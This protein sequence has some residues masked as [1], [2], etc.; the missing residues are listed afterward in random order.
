M[1][2]FGTLILLTTVYSFPMIALYPIEE[3]QNSSINR[4]W[5]NFFNPIDHMF[6]SMNSFF[7]FQ[8]PVL[9]ERIVDTVTEITPMGYRKITETVELVDANGRVDAI[10]TRIT[11]EYDFNPNAEGG[12]L[13]TNSEEKEDFVEDIV[14]DIV[15]DIQS[16]IDDS[17]NEEENQDQG[18]KRQPDNNDEILLTDLLNNVFNNV[19]KFEDSNSLIEATDQDLQEISQNDDAVDLIEED[20]KNGDEEERDLFNLIGNFL[21]GSTIEFSDSEENDID[22]DDDDDRIEDLDD[23]D[24]EEEDWEDDEEDEDGDDEDESEDIEDQPYNKSEEEIA[25]INSIMESD[26]PA[27]MKEQVLGSDYVQITE[28][29]IDED[30]DDDIMDEDEEEMP[31]SDDPNDLLD[32][33]DE[34]DDVED[35]DDPE[36]NGNTPNVNGLENFLNK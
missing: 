33:D 1:R 30:D 11:V 22:L 3:T 32:D 19:L 13:I 10:E 15:D 20:D 4:F 5:N 2:I 21:G 28:N 8:Q 7:G 12:S 27:W 25:I 16:V 31:F 9:E 24:D 23:F 17:A 36:E 26:M 6:M 14:E 35:D 18:A 34:L 29:D